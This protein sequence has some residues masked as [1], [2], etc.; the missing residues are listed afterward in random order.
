M[1]IVLIE[2]GAY[3]FQVWYELLYEIDIPNLQTVDLPNSFEYAKSR[4]FNSICMN[5]I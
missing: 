5:M 1:D 4:S 2:F 3:L